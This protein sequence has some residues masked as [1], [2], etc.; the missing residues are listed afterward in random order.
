MRILLTLVHLLLE[1]LGLLVVCKRKPCHG[2]IDLEAVEEDSIL[3]VLESIIYLLI[4]YYAS[5]ARLDYINLI[6]GERQDFEPTDKST[7]FIQY[8]FP[9]K[10]LA[11]TAAPCRPVKT[12]LCRLGYA[13]YSF[14]TPAAWILLDCFG[15]VRF[16]V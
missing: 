1:F 4:P 8:V 5:I 7:S 16:T 6:S 11:R 3:I 2:S 14:A 12:H 13:T 9:T 15:T 10:S